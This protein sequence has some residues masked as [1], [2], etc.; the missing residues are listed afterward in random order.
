MKLTLRALPTQIFSAFAVPFAVES[1]I[2]P[3]ITHFQGSHQITFDIYFQILFEFV[4]SSLNLTESF[5][6]FEIPEQN[7]VLPFLL[8]GQANDPSIAFDRSHL[9]FRCVLIG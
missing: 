3:L 9:N 5:W 1:I 8:V 4:S 2:L 7:I 6:K